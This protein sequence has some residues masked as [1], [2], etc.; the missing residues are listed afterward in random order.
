[1]KKK[2]P[3]TV[4]ESNQIYK[5][6]WIE[7]VE[8]TV[9]RPDGKE[10]MFTTV[11]NGSGVAVVALDADNTIYLVKEY[12]YVL[13]E[14]GI[15]TPSGGVSKNETPLEA[16]KKELLEE[17]GL[18]ADTW[19]ELGMV[20]ALTMIIKSPSYLFLAQGLTKQQEPE[21]GIEVIKI[22]FAEAIQKVMNSEITHGPSCVAI[23]KAKEVL[24][25]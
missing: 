6:H 9:I 17:T 20:N 5:N 10:G 23:L 15:Q 16:A 1:M 12:F 8:D 4:T 22:P 24:K 13:E 18:I 2:G 7:V 19:K 3:Y 14:Y 21:E 11:D 25:P